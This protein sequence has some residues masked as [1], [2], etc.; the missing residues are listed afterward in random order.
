MEQDNDRKNCDDKGV[1]QSLKRRKTTKKGILIT[2]VIVTAI[3]GAS[4]IVYFI[5]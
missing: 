4:F 2:A 3:I 1:V 5:P